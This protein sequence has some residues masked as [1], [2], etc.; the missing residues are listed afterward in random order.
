[1]T[2]LLR[3]LTVT[4][5]VIGAVAC[6]DSPNAP[7]ETITFTA[8]LSPANEVPPVTGPEASGTGTATI[9]FTLNRDNGT[10]ITSATVDF[11]APLTGFPAATALTAAHIH[12]GAVG[13]NGEVVVNTGLVPGEIVLTSGSATVTKS[14]IAVTPTL[15]QEIIGNPS[16]FYF[17]VHSTLNTGGMVRGQLVRQ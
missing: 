17:N 1:M 8:Q 16:G 5:L 4:G 7:T 13:T 2:N 12:R 11:S 10:A 14:G 9:T 15:A 6:D 3:A